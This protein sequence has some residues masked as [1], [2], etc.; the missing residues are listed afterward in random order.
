MT[1]LH[2]GNHIARSDRGDTQNSPFH[3]IGH[4][5][6]FAFFLW[7]RIAA[8]RSIRDHRKFVKRCVA[9]DHYSIVRVEANEQCPWPA[10]GLLRPY[11]VHVPAMVLL[12][13]QRSR[14]TPRYLGRFF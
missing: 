13:E 2:A 10:E 5:V 1:L 11:K 14:S 12:S 4:W 3:F 9:S 6:G 7:F 8:R